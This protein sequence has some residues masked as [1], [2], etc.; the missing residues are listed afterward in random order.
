[1][2]VGFLVCELWLKYRYK[3]DFKKTT[4]EVLNLCIRSNLYNSGE[5]G[6]EHEH[7]HYVKRNKYETQ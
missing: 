4:D 2:S 7:W 3:K 5:Y 6:T 1:M